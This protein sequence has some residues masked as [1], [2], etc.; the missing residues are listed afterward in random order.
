MS[1]EDKKSSDR[2]HRLSSLR[3]SA[4]LAVAIGVTAVIVYLAT[5]SHAPAIAR[6]YFMLAAMWTATASIAPIWLESLIFNG[7]TF[8]LA[9]ITWRLMTMLGAFVIATVFPSELR[10]YFLTT[11]MA[12]YFVALPL[13][14]WLLARRASK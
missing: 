2:P 4:V 5:F 13:E 8:Q 3:I 14:S 9:V 12:C 11:L 1:D 7:G 6:P 10:K